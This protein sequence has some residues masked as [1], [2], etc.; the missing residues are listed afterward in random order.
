MNYVQFHVGDWESSTRLLS[1]TEKG[2]YFDLLMLYYALERPLMRTECDRMSRAYAQT[3]KDALKYVLNRF[4]VEKDGEYSHDRCNR[5]IAA[6]H[7]KSLKAAE[8]AKARW[9]KRSK[10]NKGSV[11]N[12]AHIQ[13]ECKSDANATQPQCERICDR[14]TDAMLTNNQEPVTNNHINKDKTDKPE[15]VNVD[16]FRPDGV[17][18]E[19]WIEWKTLRK[20][21]R[22]SITQRIVD[23]LARE[24]AKANM[25]VEQAMVMQLEKD[26]RGFEADWLKSEQVKAG[27]RS[28]APLQFDDAY[29]GDGSF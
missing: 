15:R 22:W 3:E 10:A 5:E 7:E 1:P 12:D 20:K 23:A 6:Y 19:I 17:S 9:S 27:P 18:D 25:T 29:Y 8:S 21:K 4:F 11:S 13:N 16:Q 24:A 14:N 26:W 2:V 28:N